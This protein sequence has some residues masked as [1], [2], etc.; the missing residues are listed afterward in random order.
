[1]RPS[2]KVVRIPRNRK[3]D[4]MPPVTSQHGKRSARPGGAAAGHG[5]TS[6]WPVAI[7]VVA[8]IAAYLNSFSGVL[9]FDDLQGI[10]DNPHI[11]R[12]WPITQAMSAAPQ[13]T[14]AG[15]PVASLTL[16]F[17]YALGGLNVRG[18]HAVNLAIHI[19]SALLLYGLIR[20]TLLSERLR[21]RYGPHAHLLAMI[22]AAL[23]GI[24]PL[25]TESVTYVVQRTESLA[26]LFYLL[27]LYG[28]VRGA[29]SARPAAWYVLAVLACA[30]GMATKEIVVTAPLLVFLYDL[31]FSNHSLGELIR[32]RKLLYLGLAATWGVLLAIMAGEPRSAS[33]GFGL[34]YL[35]PLQYAETQPGIILHYLQLCFWPYHL[36]LDYHWPT[37]TTAMQI[38]PQ[39]MAILVLLGATVWALVRRP[40]L[41]FVGAG[42]FIILSPTSSFVPIMDL[43]F[44][45]RMYLPLALVVTFVVVAGYELLSRQSARLSFPGASRRVLGVGAALVA[46]CLLGYRTYERNRIYQSAVDMWR[47]VLSTNPANP[48]AHNNLAGQLIRQGDP[49][50]AVEH[51]RE[52]VRLRPDYQDARSNLGIALENVANRLADQGRPAEAIQLY[53]EALDFKPDNAETFNNLG[54]SLRAVGEVDQ[55]ILAYQQA[56][57]INPHYANAMI[58]LGN[59]LRQ[60][61]DLAGAIEQ[62]RAA[63]GADPD[64]ANARLML[65]TGYYE[66][67]NLEEAIKQYRI[68]LDL[69]P[70]LLH[71]RYCLGLALDKQGHVAEA[72]EAYTA[73]LA[74]N[75]NHAQ[76]RRALDTARLH[77]G[78]PTSSATP[79]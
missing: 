60:K 1:V 30:L 65:G 61:G 46:A 41:G 75:P 50:A 53:H 20:R 79:P 15:R 73:V 76:A 16:A 10:V 57:G 12:L 59:A 2:S 5:L 32:R 39:S 6:L 14:L 40:A 64:N 37:A 31:V 11:R 28:A 43:A 45:H 18:Y 62:Y 70:G 33:T 54:I 21:A 9:L 69:N 72:I 77:Q 66:Q 78:Q 38:V 19:L 42:F 71:A 4:L 3:A 67:N 44:E 56:L 34:D 55:A 25:Q 7:I 13:S 49:A 36:C 29:A 22:I 26:G 8:C 47:D 24:H 68:A 52:A 58:S 17:N 63:V 23:W 35:S 48:R 74:K 51:G 27:T